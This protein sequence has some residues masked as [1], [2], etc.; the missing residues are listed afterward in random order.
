MSGEKGASF[1]VKI[2]RNEVVKFDWMKAWWH[3]HLGMG[4]FIGLV[5]NLFVYLF[6]LFWLSI[7][8]DTN[9]SILLTPCMQHTTVN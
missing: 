1:E 7:W 9:Y 2:G 3:L 4:K 8:R 6:M 5:Y